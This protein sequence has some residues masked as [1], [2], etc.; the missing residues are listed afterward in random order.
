MTDVKKGNVRLIDSEDEARELYKPAPAGANNKIGLEVE[1]PLFRPGDIK[2]EIPTAAEIT[3]IQ[4]ALRDKGF[5]AQL[6]ASG[7]LE[8]ASAPVPLESVGTLIVN[9]HRD[10]RAFEEEIA[11]HGY[12]RA[13]F[14]VI[15]T[16]TLQE[17]L[18][19]KVPRERLDTVLAVFKECYPT[20]ITRIPLITT[21]VQA[22]FSPRSV[23]ELFRMTRRGYALTPLLIAAMN[24]SSGFADNEPKR[25]DAHLRSEYY[26]DY[27]ASG[28]LSQAFLKSENAE[29]FIRHHVAEVFDAPMFFAYDADGGVIR[30]TKED[31]LTF[32]KL[33]DRGLNTQSNYELAETFLYTDVKI[34]NIRNAESAA[35]GKRVEVRPADSGL[36]QPFS[37]LLL[38]AALIP[39]GETAER[40]DAL[41][42]DYGFTGNPAKD[43]PLLTAAHDAAV[44]HG[45]RFMD[46]PFGTGSLRDF[47]ADV[48]SLIVDHYS[49]DRRVAPDVSKL[50]DILLTGDCDAKRYAHDYH[51]LKQLTK[52]L[53]KT[54]VRP[55]AA[56]GPRQHKSPKPPKAA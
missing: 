23:E 37:T 32:R 46:V 4:Q 29:D 49:H 33:I 38:T 26:G 27:G 40:F 12:A 16:T 9:A 13:P 36:H 31:I 42:K 50:V 2:P 51:T 30:S 3:A 24:S 28:G 15:P 34:A 25:H 53:Q 6:E 52:T 47:A 8:Y 20:D 43:A 5:D 21:G 54:P 48:A 35:I 56:P 55:A 11:A 14:S 7:V 17:A 19:H 41:L 44:Q 39:D 45:G 10:I 22:N 18:D 1:M